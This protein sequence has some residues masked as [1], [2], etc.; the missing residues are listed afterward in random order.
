MQRGYEIINR[1]T[2][3]NLIFHWNLAAGGLFWSRLNFWG[4]PLIRWYYFAVSQEKFN[5]KILGNVL[6][7]Q[8]IFRQWYFRDFDK[9]FFNKFV[10]SLSVIP[11][12][13]CIPNN[14]FTSLLPFAFRHSFY[15]ASQWRPYKWSKFNLELRREIK[16]EIQFIFAM[17]WG[18]RSVF[19]WNTSS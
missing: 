14:L 1:T 5:W 12:L 18:A 7:D 2:R 9:S 19:L 6:R 13:V 11:F 8:L 15:I 10:S 3:D 4:S 16:I 17:F